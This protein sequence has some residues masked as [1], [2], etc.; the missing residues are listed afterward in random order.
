MDYSYTSNTIKEEEKVILDIVRNRDGLEIGGPSNCNNIYNNINK[1]DNITIFKNGERE[2]NIKN[3]KLGIE[4]VKDTTNLTN[5]KNN[6]YDFILV[7]NTLEYIANPIKAIKE[8]LRIL[9][10]NGF[11]IMIFDNISETDDNKFHLKKIIE[12]YEKNIGEDDLSV[13]PSILSKSKT[14]ETFIRE[15]LNNY[16]LRKI[17]HFNYNEKL[18]SGIIEY[19]DLGV[20]Y[21]NKSDR[22]VYI[23]N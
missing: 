9:K 10:Q 6:T 4:Y 22:L 19:L 13:L 5:I 23:I 1:L 15:C 20:F 2:Y 21:N 14:N 18:L 3:K 12:N 7:S 17:E 16:H 8:W 11:I